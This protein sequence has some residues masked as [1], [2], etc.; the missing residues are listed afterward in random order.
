MGDRKGHFLPGTLFLFAG[1]FFLLLCQRRSRTGHALADFIPEKNPAVLLYAGATV[2]GATLTGLLLEAIVCAATC[3]K[4]LSF[5]SR[6]THQSLHECLYAAFA[7]VG[8]T[9]LL[10][11]RARLP[12]DT[13][14][15]MLCIALFVES[16]LWASHA[17]MQSGAE[18]VQHELLNTLSLGTS[19]VC[20][21]SIAV[22]GD[23]CV[24]LAVWALLVLQGVWLF[25]IGAEMDGDGGT[26]MTMDKVAPLFYAEG[27]LVATAVLGG[28]AYTRNPASGDGIEGSG[29]GG[30][31]GALASFGKARELKQS[32]V[33]VNKSETDSSMITRIQSEDGLL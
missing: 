22:P 28:A 31:K 13:W 21:V 3:P 19:F 24:H 29:E 33:G 17:G 2:L 23:A 1:L 4:D 27:V 26:G 14:R 5:L 20:A 18:R 30:R 25:S 10:E 7:L 9:A 16:Q 15:R 11:S 6:L 12:L 32:Y 8:L